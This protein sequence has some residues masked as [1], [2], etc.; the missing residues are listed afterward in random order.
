MVSLSH[1]H[2]VI[3]RIFMLSSRIDMIKLPLKLQIKTW[4]FALFIPFFQFIFV[5][6]LQ[7]NQGFR[8]DLCFTAEKRPENIRFVRGKQ[9]LLHP[10]QERRVIQLTIDN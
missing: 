5:C 8:H 7:S 4:D 3:Y 9:L 1:S 10:L 6:N 2:R